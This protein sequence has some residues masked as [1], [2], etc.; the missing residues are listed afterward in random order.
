MMKKAVG[1]IA[2]LLAAAYMTGGNPGV[3]FLI[4][5]V[6]VYAL[7]TALWDYLARHKWV[8]GVAVACLLLAGGNGAS[9]ALVS[10][11]AVVVFVAL[12]VWVL[13]KLLGGH[14][15]LP[16]RMANSAGDAFGRGMMNFLNRQPTQAELQE[17]ARRKAR[18][19]YA[20]HSFQAQKYQGT[21][22]GEWHKN[23]AWEARERMK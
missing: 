1:V 17:Q 12:I 13:K 7:T 21:R 20:F 3:G 5:A 9:S 4:I 10:L 19:D 18:E 15:T 16:S 11:G 8:A 14:Q 23:R 22:D 2:A 6:I